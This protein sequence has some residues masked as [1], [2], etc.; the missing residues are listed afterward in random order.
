ME[1]FNATISIESMDT[2]A[3]KRVMEEPAKVTDHLYDRVQIVETENYKRA[4]ECLA[5]SFL[6]DEVARYFVHTDVH[7]FNVWTPETRKLHDEIFQYITYAHCLRGLVTT[8][9]PNYDCVALW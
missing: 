1:K 4:A 9:G 6:G 7:G 2:P 3:I 8:I 5:E